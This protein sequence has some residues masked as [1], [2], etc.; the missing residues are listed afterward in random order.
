MSETPALE[1]RETKRAAMTGR[2][3]I[4]LEPDLL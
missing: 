4:A 1:G 3:M 2:R